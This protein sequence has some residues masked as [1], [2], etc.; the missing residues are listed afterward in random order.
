MEQATR[1]Q[2]SN[3][4]WRGERLRH[5]TSSNFATIC[6]ATDRRDMSVL[7]KSLVTQQKQ[8]RAPAI[9]HGQKYEAVAVEKY[10]DAMCSGTFECGMFISTSHPMLA[11]SPDR[12]VDGNTLLEVKCPYSARHQVISQIT[13]PYLKSVDGDLQLDKSHSYYYQIQGQLYCAD[14]GSCDF[15]VYTIKDM[16]V[17]R[18]V[19]DDQFIADMLEKLLNF[20]KQFYQSALLEKLLFRNYYDYNF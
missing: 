10:E 4:L 6:K 1:G 3:R 16:V 5:V 18:V 2:S 9:L 13:V 17:I 12:V 14:K 20:Y 15:V 7:A 19:R 11:A 8:L